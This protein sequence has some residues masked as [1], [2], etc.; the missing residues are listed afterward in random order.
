MD[1]M[2]ERLKIRI[3]TLEERIR[4]LEHA[5]VPDGVSVPVEWCLTQ[6]EARVFSHL[7][8][9]EVATKGS[10]MVALYS[11][12]PNGDEIEPK[13]VDVFVC[14]LRKKLNR[15]G[16]QIM[17]VWGQGYSLNNREHFTRAAA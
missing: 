17:T 6:A 12:R 8:T 4:Q 2:V 5:L 7:T 11:D 13:I 3:E 14:K 9:R 15:F 16:I 1:E 10:L